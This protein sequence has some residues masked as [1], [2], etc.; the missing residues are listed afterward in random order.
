MWNTRADYDRTV[1]RKYAIGSFSDML[2]ASCKHP[3][4]LTY[5]SLCELDQEHDQRELRPRDA[6]AAHRRLA[7]QRERRAEH[8]AD[9]DRTHARSAPALRLRRLHPRDRR[10]LGARLHRPEHEGGSAAR[11]PATGC[12]ATSR[13][14]RTPRRTSPASSA[15]ASCPTT[16]PASSS[17]ASRRPTS[18]TTRRSSRRCRQILCS[19]EFWESR[20][21][22]MRRPAENIVAAV[23]ALG[24]KLLHV[25]RRAA[26]AAL[27]VQRGLGDAAA[28]LAGAER[29]RG[30]RDAMA[31]EQRA[32]RRR[33]TTTSRFAGRWCAGLRTRRHRRRFYGGDPQTS[34][35]AIDMLTNRLTGMTFVRHRPADAA[36][37]PRRPV[38]RHAD[39]GVRH[40]LVRALP[41]RR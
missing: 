26:D 36:D 11:R 35:E 9:A 16:R 22:K 37:V 13:R 2:V 1:I 38:L 8:G 40:A 27:D 6:R 31:L 30:R 20:G 19:T 21:L 34:G 28:R 24:S 10:G 14:T 3:A 41:R 7:L 33:G 32:A 25:A 29:L 4:M 17:P 18:T 39:G 23:R 15:C 12:C 5:L